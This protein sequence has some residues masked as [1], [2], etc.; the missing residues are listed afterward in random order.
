MKNKIKEILERETKGININDKTKNE[1]IFSYDDVERMMEKVCGVTSTNSVSKKRGFGRSYGYN[2]GDTKSVP[3]CDCKMMVGGTGKLCPKCEAEKELLKDID[4]KVEEM[5]LHQVLENHIECGKK[6]DSCLGCIRLGINKGYRY[7]NEKEC[8]Q[9]TKSVPKGK[10][11]TKAQMMWEVSK[12]QEETFRKYLK[13]DTLNEINI[14]ELFKLIRGAEY[15]RGKEDGIKESNHSQGAKPNTAVAQVKTK[16][17][18]VLEGAET[19][20]SSGS[21]PETPGTFP[22]NHAHHTNCPLDKNRLKQDLNLKND[23]LQGKSNAQKPI[24][25]LRKLACGHSRPTNVSFSLKNYEKPKVGDM[26]YCRECCRDSEIL[27]VEECKEQDE[28]ELKEK[29]Q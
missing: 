1:L 15:R 2:L 9:D 20:A 5:I 13:Q 25:W 29:K 19:S 11:P 3:E 21:N 4:A 16:S 24:L 23:N 18:N 14:D 22:E 27:I 8:N 12:E 6:N 17:E 7:A 28:N 10:Y 26:C